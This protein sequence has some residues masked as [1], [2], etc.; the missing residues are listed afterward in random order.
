MITRGTVRHSMSKPI[1]SLSG[2]GGPRIGEV[3]G[4][5]NLASIFPKDLYTTTRDV[6]AYFD[7]G[8]KWT[9]NLQRLLFPL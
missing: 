2:S 3:S 8:N 9:R 4:T 6:L 1:L 7:N 5:S